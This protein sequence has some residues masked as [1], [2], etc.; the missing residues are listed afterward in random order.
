MG[1]W[2]LWMQQRM[3]DAKLYG[4]TFPGIPVAEIAGDSRVL[5]EHHKGIREYEA[6]RIRICV[7]YGEICVCGREL[8]I[9]KMTSA[10]IVIAGKIENL[11]LIR[12]DR[13]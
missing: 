7:S 10:Q 11:Q 8:S 1:D 9:A 5:I 3:E 2:T 6:D 4:E 12:R 13:R